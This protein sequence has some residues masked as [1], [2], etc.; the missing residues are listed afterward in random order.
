MNLENFQCNV[1]QTRLS[2][3]K[4][5]NMNSND[6]LE[7]SGLNNTT[8]G[9]WD[10]NNATS[11]TSNTNN[12]KNKSKKTKKPCALCDRPRTRRDLCNRCR[13][14]IETRARSLNEEKILGDL[15]VFKNVIQFINENI[16]DDMFNS[17]T[18]NEYN[19]LLNDIFPY[20]VCIWYII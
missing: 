20:L 12:T 8:V 1:M 16:T 4:K 14:K 3:H 9:D 18:K 19:Q 2:K 17:L 13:Q 15:L 11:N 5:D 7:N 6:T 10:D